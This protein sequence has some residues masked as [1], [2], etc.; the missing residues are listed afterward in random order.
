MKYIEVSE[1]VSVKIEDIESVSQSDDGLTSIIKTDYNTYK[2]TFPY[3]VL[4]ELLETNQD[5]RVEEKEMQ[6]QELNIL[7]QIGTPAW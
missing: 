4:L 3:S 1:G 2:S 6:R 7:K 5:N